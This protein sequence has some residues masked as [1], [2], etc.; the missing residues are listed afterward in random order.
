[1]TRR[2]HRRLRRNALSCAVIGSAALLAVGF[3]PGPAG[4]DPDIAPTEQA[5]A[6]FIGAAP[7]APAGGRTLV[8]FAGTGSSSGSAGSRASVPVSA[9]PE[10]AAY[11]AAFGYGV[12]HPDA[13]PPGANDWNCRLTQEHPRPVVLAHG[14]WLNAYD[15]FAYLAPQ[16]VRAGFCVFALNYGQAN[17]LEGGGFGAILPGRNG[18][19]YMEDSAEQLGGFI[20]RVRAATGVDQVDIV[21]HSQGG[22]VAD[23]YLKFEG[24]V[25]KVA[26]V[27]T[28]G[29]TH[30]GTTLFGMATLG[31]AINNLGVDILGFNELFVGHANI[32]QA[33]GSPFY[34]K[35][36]QAGDTVPGVE[37]TVVGSQHDEVTNPYE[38]TF[39]TAGPDATVHNITLQDG[40]AQDMSDHLTMMYSPRAVSIALRAL[41]PDAHPNLVCAFNPWFI[42]GGGGL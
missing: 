5:L 9:G 27:V 29:A 13:S 31:R 16:L 32:E 12:L 42:G 25:G 7:G 26:R 41:D 28:F 36:N 14:T 19:G 1:M 20:D 2:N 24:G 30:H 38:L 6:D 35:L 8:A 11:F 22:A 10:V 39:L 17:L 23:Q 33:I 40:C 37:Y 34:A 4:A 21:A 18:V 15:S 3:G